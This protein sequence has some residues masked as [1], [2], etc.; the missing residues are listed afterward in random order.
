[1]AIQSCSVYVIEKGIFLRHAS[2]ITTHVIDAYYQD[3]FKQFQVA[4]NFDY[5]FEVP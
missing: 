2:Y 3:N 4:H 1:M 5:N